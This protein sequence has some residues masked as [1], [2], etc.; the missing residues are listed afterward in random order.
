MEESHQRESDL[1][2]YGQ[3][4]LKRNSQRV[5]FM[6]VQEICE[7]LICDCGP[8]TEYIPDF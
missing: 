6:A 1:Y 2:H 7:K 4:L 5:T 8:V 3:V